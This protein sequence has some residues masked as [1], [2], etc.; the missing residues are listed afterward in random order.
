MCRP[1]GLRSERLYAAYS[2]RSP[3]GLPSFK[4]TP[5]ERDLS[6]VIRAV[7]DDAVKQNPDGVLEPGHRRVECVVLELADVGGQPPMSEAELLNCKPPLVEIGVR[8]GVR[9]ELRV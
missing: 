4:R 8:R 2:S 1:K 5:Q 9:P 7:F 6:R 3:S